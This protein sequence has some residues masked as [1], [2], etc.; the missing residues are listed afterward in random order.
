MYQNIYL[1]LTAVVIS[2]ISDGKRLNFVASR[3]DSLTLTEA[4]TDFKRNRTGSQDFG[5]FE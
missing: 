1:F 4:E 2:V 5:E 3:K